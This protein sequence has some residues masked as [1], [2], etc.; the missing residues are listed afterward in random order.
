M[1]LADLC[2][3]IIILC[4]V[5]SRVYVP[6]THQQIHSE[7]ST[8][9]PLYSTHHSEQSTSIPIDT[10]TDSLRVENTHPP[11]HINRFTQSRVHPSPST[12]Q[13]IHSEKSTPIPLYTSTD[14]LREEYTYPLLDIDRFTVTHFLHS[15]HSSSSHSFAFTTETEEFRSD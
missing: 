2:K 5:Q 6:S 11:L 8:P 1:G 14:S 12:H 15:T 7:Y 13:Q 3:D 4:G 9:I 10:S